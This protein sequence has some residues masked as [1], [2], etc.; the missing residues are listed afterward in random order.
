MVAVVCFAACFFTL[1]M[2]VA[3]GCLVARLFTLHVL[4]LH[5]G[6]LLQSLIR[7]LKI[8]RT[9]KQT[10]T[11]MV[12]NDNHI[13][14]AIS[15]YTISVARTKIY[16]YSWLLM[17]TDLGYTRGIQKNRWYPAGRPKITATELR[18]S[19]RRAWD[20]SKKGCGEASCDVRW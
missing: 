7:T 5:R 16:G 6:Q 9:L 4:L 14:T 19:R 17:V 15:R 13:V 8:R 11:L 3:G 2:Q 18:V 12:S 1:K 10:S 20:P